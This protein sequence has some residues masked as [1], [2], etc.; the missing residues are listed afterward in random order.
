MIEA[1]RSA[2]GADQAEAGNP[3]YEKLLDTAESLFAEHGY[4]AVSVRAV[5]IEA[6][7]NIAAVHYHFGS[8]I[9]L[10]RAVYE[11]RTVALNAEREQLLAECKERADGRPI[12]AE[13]I[14][15]FVGP[16]FRTTP[17][18]ARLSAKISVETSPAVRAVA[19]ATIGAVIPQ[20]VAA[21][22]AARPDLDRDE[23]AWRFSC[24][25]GALMFARVDTGFIRRAIGE[26][27]EIVDWDVAFEAIMPFLTAGFDAP[28]ATAAKARARSADVRSRTAGKIR[29]R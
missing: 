19:V 29:R 7:A 26:A 5:T 6:G 4:G 16:A 10:L 17:G 28:A 8:K 14:R 11:R 12:V 25:I 21:L 27:V 15:A 24:V 20:F 22:S 9:D 23:I 13:I 2:P 3:T 18:F 1:K